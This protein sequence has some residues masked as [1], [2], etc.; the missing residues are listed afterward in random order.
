MAAQRYL[1]SVA[2]TLLHS[3]HAVK[4]TCTLLAYYQ[5]MKGPLARDLARLRS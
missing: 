2:V 4:L 5:A 3:A 1:P